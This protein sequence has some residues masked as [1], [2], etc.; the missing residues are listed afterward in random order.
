MRG[1]VLVI[2]PTAQARSRATCWHDGQIEHGFDARTA[3]RAKSVALDNYGPPL[4][5]NAPWR[6]WS[7]FSEQG[8]FLLS[9]AGT[10]K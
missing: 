7:M 4:R 10:A 2:C 9:R 6:I 8:V 3:H 1:K 5:L